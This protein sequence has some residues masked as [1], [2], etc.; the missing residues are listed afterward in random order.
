MALP[1]WTIPWRRGGIAACALR[2][3][4]LLGVARRRRG[5]RGRLR[6]VVR[7]LPHR[8]AFDFGSFWFKAQQIRTGQ[9]NV[10]A[11][12]RRLMNL[13]HAGRAKP[14]RIISRPLTLDEAPNAFKHFEARGDGWTKAVLKPAA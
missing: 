3:L 2:G 10:K 14:S 11:Y 12:N 5:E 1:A 8:L 13:I 4:L 9:R 6:H 7:N